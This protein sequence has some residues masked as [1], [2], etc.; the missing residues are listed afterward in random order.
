M[1]DADSNLIPPDETAYDLRL[2]AVELKVAYNA[3]RSYFDDFGHD[4]ADV[5]DVV[6]GILSKLPGEP[7]IQAIDLDAELAKL[8]ALRGQG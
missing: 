3:L 2:T 8:R 5:Q 4:E 6:R 7:E 1:T